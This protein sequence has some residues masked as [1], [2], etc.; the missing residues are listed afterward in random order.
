[1]QYAQMLLFGALTSSH[2]LSQLYHFLARARFD[3]ACFLL[4]ISGSKTM[5]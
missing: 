4:L 1:M 5:L 2:I 3:R